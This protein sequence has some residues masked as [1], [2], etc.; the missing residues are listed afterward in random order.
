MRYV[1]ASFVLGTMGSLLVACAAKPPAEIG[2]SCPREGRP[3]S[4]DDGAEGAFVCEDDEP[5]CVCDAPAPDDDDDDAPMDAGRDAGRD[6]ARPRPDARVTDAR[7]AEDP[8]DAGP[9]EPEGPALPSAPDNCPML[10]SGDVEVM[11]QKVRLWV[12]DKQGDARGP[13]LFYW[14]ATDGS[15]AE[16]ESGLGKAHAEILAEGGIIASFTTS[17][18]SGQTTGNGVWSTG[19]FEMADVLIA[20]AVA[21]HGIDTR[22]IYTAGCDAGG[23]QAAAMAYAR[24]SYLAAAVPSSGGTAFPYQLED[25]Q[26]VPAFMGAHGAGDKVVIDFAEATQRAAKDLAGKGG[27][28]I[29]CD[30]GGGHCASPTSVKNAQWQFL[31]DHPWGVDP[32]P[33]SEELPDAFPTACKVVT[34]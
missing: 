2:Q 17:T 29:V 22:R 4:C 7:G 16:A 11:G 3:C 34:K 33:Y 23:L 5:V 27:F 21:Q 15:A 10:E 30:H 31:K 8:P 18:G 1:F 14:H 13:I 32:E 20:C 6:A 9:A 25:A 19:D 28:A 26:H 24:S 12:G